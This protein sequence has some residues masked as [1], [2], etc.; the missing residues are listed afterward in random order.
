MDCGFDWNVYANGIAISLEF[1][2][3]SRDREFLGISRAIFESSISRF[4]NRDISR[5]RNH[6]FF[7]NLLAIFEFSLI[8]FFKN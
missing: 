3:E 8:F 1:A 4:F 6:Y 7:I 2:V 5:P